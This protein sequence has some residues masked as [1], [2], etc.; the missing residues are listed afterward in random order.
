VTHRP[1]P[2]AP[3]GPVEFVFVPEGVRA[4]IERAR[5][6]AGDRYATIGGGADVAR[7]A[8]AAGLVDE[9]QVH[10]VP[11]LLGDGVALFDGTGPAWRLTRLRVIDA[12]GV[13]HL[14]YRVEGPRD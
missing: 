6:A 3:G 8:L 9:V 7:Q 14:R 5:D 1:P 4:A 2:V 11:V 12:P 10:V 13:T